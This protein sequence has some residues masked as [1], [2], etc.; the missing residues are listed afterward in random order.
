MPTTYVVDVPFQVAPPHNEDAQA[1]KPGVVR[2]LE[3]HKV[4][5]LALIVALGFCLRIRG[6]DRMGFN[7]DE[8]TVLNAARAYLGGNFLLNREHPMF[9]KSMIAVSL[10]AGDRWNRGLGRSHQVSDEIAVRLPNTIIGALTAVVIFLFAQEFFDFQVGLLSALLWS[11]GTFAI[12]VN[13]LAKE[14][15]FLVFFTWFAY[16]SYRRAKE[17]SAID[18]RW[19]EKWYAASG[20]SFGLMMASKY[21]PHFMGLN[22]LYYYLFPNKRKYPRLSWRGNAALLGACTLVFLTAN[23][24]VV[25]PSTVKY[26]LH[27]VAE[28]NMTHHGYLMMGRFYYDD[29]A[30]LRG[31]MPIF[32][33][34]LLLLIKTP[35]PVLG[36]FA[37][38]LVDVFRRRREPGPYFV[39]LMFFFWIIPFS[40]LSAKW[41]R[42]MLSWMPMVYIISAIGIVKLLS[43][44]SN[45]ALQRINRRWVPALVTVLAAVFL[46]EPVWVAAKSGPFY[47]LYLNSVGMGRT[48]YYFPHD[49]VND[50]G[51]REAIR[52]IC[53]EAPRGASVGGESGSVFAYYFH[54]FGRDDLQ[55][56]DLSDQVRRVEAPPSA[57][58]VVQD[59]RK[60]FENMTFI[61][62]VESHQTPI[63]VVNVGGAAAASIY[64][65]EGFAQLGKV[66]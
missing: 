40:L 12:A 34:P 52:Q 15:T 24:T 5:A 61:Q 26:D 2:L 1:A 8:I 60:Y 33:Y 13:R 21:F 31:G 7:E 64:R 23:P 49:E 27:Y 47:P 37:F 38:G 55:Y 66:Q 43:W 59:G 58:L 35:L 44:C 63:H 54:K 28:G 17:L 48:A 62:K 18:V 39:L 25:L 20:A 29:P 36:A 10:A 4:V 50:A 42:W 19:G 16:Y 57:Y 9:M 45:T 56:F 65:S 3:R 53:H 6:L 14:D 30:H 46:L 11:V 22:A 41:L 32:F 51:L